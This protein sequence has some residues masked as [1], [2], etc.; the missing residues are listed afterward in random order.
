MFTNLPDRL[1]IALQVVFVLALLG[2]AIA[3][4]LSMGV[5]KTASESHLVYFEVKASGGFAVITLRASKE[6][7]TTP[8]TVT[9]P[10]S[11]TLRIKSGTE[12]YLTAANPS[13]TGDL[14]CRI[15]LDKIAWKAEKNSAPKNGVACA[16]I[17]P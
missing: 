13:E 9:V 8:T 10:W 5:M 17:V 1:R 11:K 15:T 12:V 7:I 2:G 6:S 14:S 16:G 4:L 3:I